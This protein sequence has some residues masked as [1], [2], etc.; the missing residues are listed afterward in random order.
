[1]A[2][3]HVAGA[4]RGR[5]AGGA[6]LAAQGPRQAGQVAVAQPLVLRQTHHA[7]PRQRLQQIT[8]QRRQIIV[9]QRTR[10]IKSIK[11]ISWYL[12]PGTFK[13]SS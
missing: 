5:R 3:G 1:V 8:W 9:V 11:P 7:Q 10:F 2:A 6:L 12:Q 13:P 4:G